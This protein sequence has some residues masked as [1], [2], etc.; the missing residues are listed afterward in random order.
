MLKT[1]QSVPQLSMQ[2]LL[3]ETVC[4]YHQESKVIM[5]SLVPWSCDHSPMT[6]VFHHYQL[7]VWC[8]TVLM[9]FEKKL[10]QTPVDLRCFRCCKTL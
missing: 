5:K 3:G 2:G 4:L 7:L 8:D 9:N 10:G 6:T 1:L